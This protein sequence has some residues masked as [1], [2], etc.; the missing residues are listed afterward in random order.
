MLI[1]RATHL[2]TPIKGAA[3][4]SSLAIL[5]Y[6]LHNLFY[7]VF[8]FIIGAAADKFSKKTLLSLGYFLTGISSLGFILNTTNLF[9]L[10]LFFLLAGIAIAIT[11][12]LERTLA[13][14]LLPEQLRGTG[15]GTLATVNGVGDFLSSTTVGFL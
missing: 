6:T 8:S 10:G 11:D 12:A 1:L 4:A 7:A 9:Y 13:A 15:Y 2:L 14:D 3:I 5:L